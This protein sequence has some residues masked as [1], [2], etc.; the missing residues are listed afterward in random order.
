MK[1]GHRH[2][3]CGVSVKHWRLSDTGTQLIREVAKLYRCWICHWSNNYG[4]RFQ[5]RLRACD[6]IW[7]CFMRMSMKFCYVL[8]ECICCSSFLSFS[9]LSPNL[10]HAINWTWDL[11]FDSVNIRSTD[12]DTKIVVAVPDIDACPTPGHN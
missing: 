6:K 9:H 2:K 1:H 12:I 7:L 8:W 4:E 11:H 10:L 3:N 5:Q